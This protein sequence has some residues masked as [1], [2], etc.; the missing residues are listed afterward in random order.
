[1]DSIELDWI[2]LEKSGLDLIG[3][4]GLDGIEVGISSKQEGLQY[5]IL[6]ETENKFILLDYQQTSIC[7]EFESIVVILEHFTDM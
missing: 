7:W 3:F 2:G 5:Y 1:V 4:I 6:L